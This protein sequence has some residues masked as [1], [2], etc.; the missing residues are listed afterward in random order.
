MTIKVE[1]FVRQVQPHR[2]LKDISNVN[3]L[4]EETMGLSDF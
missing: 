2:S 3:N 4:E 1:D